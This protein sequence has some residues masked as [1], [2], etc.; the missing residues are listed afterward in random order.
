MNKLEKAIFAAGCFW[1]VQ[2]H[3]DALPGVIETIVGYTGGHTTLADY[4]SVCTGTTGHA[5]AVELLF[6]PSIISYEALLQHFWEIHDPTTLNR[7]GP[8]Q[9]SQYRSALFW[10]S[11]EQKLAAEKSQANRQTQ[12]AQP[13]VTEITPTTLFHKAEEYHQHYF[14]KNN[15]SHCNIK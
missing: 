7:Q 12:L 9:G 1:G 15:R 4:P 5:E 2:A 6:E 11:D 8:D 13:I 3:F 14:K 10:H